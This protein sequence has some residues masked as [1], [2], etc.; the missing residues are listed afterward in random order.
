MAYLD[1][2]GT[3]DNKTEVRLN[4]HDYDSF[5]SKE[6]ALN[7]L[8]NTL[9]EIARLSFVNDKMALLFDDYYGKLDFVLRTHLPLFHDDLLSELMA[10]AKQEGELEK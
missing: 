5:R 3:Y 2:V 4:L 8:L 9:A 7:V 10:K 6:A 1:R